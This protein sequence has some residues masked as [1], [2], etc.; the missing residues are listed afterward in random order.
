MTKKKT[1][2]KKLD[3]TSVDMVR[4]GANQKADIMLYKSA[5]E[6]EEVQQ[7]LMKSIQDAVSKWWNGQEESDAMRELEITKA[8]YLD[9]LEFSLNSIAEDDTMDDV[10]KA[11]M[12]A[13]SIG[14]FSDA[15]IET[16]CKAYGQEID[17][18]SD[19]YGE[20]DQIL[21]GV[22]KTATEATTGGQEA[23][24]KK[25]EGER[26]MKIDKSRFTAEE[27]KQYQA[28]IAKAVVDEEEE[29]MEDTM[30][31]EETEKAEDE[32]MTEEEDPMKKKKT[33]KSA[34]IHPEVKKALEKIESMQKSMEMRELT[35]VA[36]K[37]A[38]LGEKEDELANTLYDLKKSGEKNYDSYIALL[39]KQMDMV[40][41]SGMFE[42]IGKSG[43]G[44]VTGGTVESKINSIASDI[45][46]AD[47]NMNYYEAVAKAWDTNPDL[48]AEY[49]REFQGGK[50]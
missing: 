6:E 45:M 44:G 34:E 19:E 43:H 28:L 18:Y 13:E 39:D 33:C 40:N 49:E 11:E 46:K 17:G 50:R 2:L 23:A 47:P 1:R 8:S 10:T 27:L 7:G 20:G 5:P 15:M 30:E 35:E 21:D 37:Y 16:V 12:A 29:Y 38:V 22:H 14:Q 25:E 32:M 31:E 24:K 9:A 26:K 36:K 42:E 4:R 3:M 48:L 41:K